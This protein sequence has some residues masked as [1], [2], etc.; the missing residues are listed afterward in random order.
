MLLA[1]SAQDLPPANTEQELENLAD[2]DQADTEDDSNLQQLVQFKKNPINLNSTDG[3]ELNELKI[4]T[5]IQ[6]ENFLSYRRIFGNLVSIYELQA[7]PTWGVQMI[8]KILLYVT[9][10]NSVMI[11]DDLIKRLR[12]GNHSLLFRFTMPLEKAIG[13]FS[14]PQANNYFG[15]RDRIFFRYKYQYKNLLQYG[16]TG[17]KDSGEQFFK[18][19]QKSGFDF[20]SFHFFAA[21]IRS[22]Q[23]LAIGD[24]TINMGQGLI[25]WQSM[26]FKKSADVLGIKRQSSILKPYNS[27]GEFYFHR[28]AGITIKKNKI[29]ITVFGSVRKLSVHLLKDTTNNKDVVSSFL[30]SGYHRTAGELHDRNNLLQ[31]AFGGNIIYKTNRWHISINDIH[32]YFS[33]PLQK[34]DEPYNLFAIRGNS[35]Y[36]LSTDYSYTW[37]NIHFFGEGAIDKHFHTAFIN[38]LLVS[39]D[40]RVDLCFLHRTINR[41]YQAI[42]GNAFTESSSPTNETGWYAGISIHP[43]AVLRMDAYADFYKFPWLRYL[44][45]APGFGKDFLAQLTYVPG[46]EV[47]LYTRY[48]NESKDLNKTLNSLATNFAVMVPRKDWRTQITFKINFSITM[49][50]RI[51]MVWYGN[52]EEDQVNGFLWFTDILYKPLLKPYSGNL[53]LQYFETDDYSSRIYAYEN[54]VQYSFSIPVLSG[55]GFHYYI[56]ISYDLNKRFSFWIKWSRLI[57]PQNKSVGSGLDEIKGNRRTEIKLQTICNIN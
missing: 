31:Y 13:F 49:R 20:Y 35:W 29:E 25:Q 4:L 26:G 36:N 37:R 22:V 50:N 6:I 39:V 17:D 32:Y 5:E 23:A 45:D 11:G 51:E 34:K 55:K 44:V 42:N 10:N 48:R 38:G 57:Y 53:R 54:D 30:A 33:L 41:A 46:K 21:K 40:S 12:K 52:K 56:N 3:A 14:S 27:A 9:L 28:G 24:F 18:G 7:V 1:V 43:T 19:K 16:I 8:R 2:A 15:G 47:E